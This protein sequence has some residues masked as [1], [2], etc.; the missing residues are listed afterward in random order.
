MSGADAPSDE[1][2]L[3]PGNCRPLMS[4]QRAQ[5]I[6]R[7]HEGAYCRAKA[8]AGG[9]QMCRC[10]T[11]LTPR[12]SVVPGFR[13]SRV[14][15]QQRGGS[16]P[17]RHG[18]HRRHTAATPPT[19]PPHQHRRPGHITRLLPWWPA[20]EPAHGITAGPEPQYLYRIRTGQCMNIDSGQHRTQL[21]TRHHVHQTFGN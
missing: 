1:G 15:A 11:R 8:S 6:R 19:G 18:F 10:P 12:A 13:R 5:R 20:I 16:R 14:L 17:T 4:E 9:R 7:W 2:E 3:H 21:W